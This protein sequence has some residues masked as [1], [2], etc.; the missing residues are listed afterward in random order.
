MLLQAELHGRR[1]WDFQRSKAVV[2]VEVLGWCMLACVVIVQSAMLLGSGDQWIEV[3]SAHFT[4]MS[5]AGQGSAKT[6]AWQLE[7]IRSAIAALWSWARVDLNKPLLVLA[8]KDEASMKGLVPSYW[9]KKGGV[10][11]ESVWVGGVDQSYLAIRTDVKVEDNGT[12]NPYVTSY[13]SYVSLILHQSGG[14]ESAVVVYAR[15]RR[16]VEQHHR[17]RVGDP[18]RSTNPMAS[19]ASPRIEPRAPGRC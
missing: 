14:R 16:G 5:N 19:A 2:A 12:V 4:V 3:K 7:Q 17:A 1:Q 13:F 18:A 15:P 10:H 9:E 11:P 6:L 8:V